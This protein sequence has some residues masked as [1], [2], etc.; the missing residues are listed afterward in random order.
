MFLK[1]YRLACR[2]LDG[3][4]VVGDPKVDLCGVIY[5]FSVSRESELTE[6]GDVIIDLYV[7]CK[8]EGVGILLRT[9]A[10]LLHSF[11][12]AVYCR[13]FVAVSPDIKDAKGIPRGFCKVL[14]MSEDVCARGIKLSPLTF[15]IAVTDKK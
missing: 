3:L 14:K 10:E 12:S 6:C 7:S 8:P 5:R 13:E 9:L 11:P 1:V 2:D 15:F 4:V